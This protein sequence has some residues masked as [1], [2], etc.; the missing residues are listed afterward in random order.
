LK[1]IS[2]SRYCPWLSRCGIQIYNGTLGAENY[3]LNPIYEAEYEI[4]YGVWLPVF[5]RVHAS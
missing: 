5:A 3:D 4:S 1:F 2:Y